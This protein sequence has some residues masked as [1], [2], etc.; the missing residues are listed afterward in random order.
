MT[1]IFSQDRS[2]A[3]EAFAKVY[4][5]QGLEKPPLNGGVNP[6][7]KSGSFTITIAPNR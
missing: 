2:P 1:A 4:A 7:M 6:N 3:A 5:E